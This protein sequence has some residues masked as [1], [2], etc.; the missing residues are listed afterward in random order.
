MRS[1]IWIITLT[2]CFENIAPNTA[3][4][5]S[6]P[7]ATS[8]AK[9]TTTRG[10]DGTYTSIVDASSMTDWT[11]GD[12]ESG[13]ESAE[14]ASW[15]LKFQRVRISSNAEVV[16]IEGV[17]FAQ[18]VAAPTTGWVSD[19]PDGKSAFEQ[20]D[21]WYDYNSMSHALAPKPLVWAV[22]TVEGA[23]IKLEIMSYYDDAGTAGWFTLHWSPL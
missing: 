2:G 8:N 7:D 13:A 19:A 1:W 12:F 4:D 6:Q 17:A 18:V 14:S 11:Y 22:K 15:D 23:T 21:G 5:D 16:A 3:D 20:G 9:F 10:T